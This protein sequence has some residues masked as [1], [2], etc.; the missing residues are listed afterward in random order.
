MRDVDKDHAWLCFIGAIGA[1]FLNGALSYGSGIIHVALL[2]SLRHPY[3]EYGYSLSYMAL[4][5]LHIPRRQ[6]RLAT[7][8][9]INAVF[10]TSSLKWSRS[11][12]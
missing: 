5:C 10:A 4:M 11:A 8:E 2:D 1:S 7:K 9:P 6:S 3:V 12:T